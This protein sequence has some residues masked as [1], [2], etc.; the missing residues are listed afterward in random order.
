MSKWKDE[1]QINA[2]GKAFN[3]NYGPIVLAG[4]FAAAIVVGV[5]VNLIFG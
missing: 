3:G 1:P 4:L 5:F 2:D